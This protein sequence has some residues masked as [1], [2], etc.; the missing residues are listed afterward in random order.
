ML[1]LTLAALFSAQL[2]LARPAASSQW[3]AQE[4]AA[5]AGEDLEAGSQ[6][7]TKQQPPGEGSFLA[8]SSAINCTSTTSQLAPFTFRHPSTPTTTT[9]RQTAP[10]LSPTPT[11]AS[12]RFHDTL[13]IYY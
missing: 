5:S 9:L 11:T 10:P 12:R 3:T 4:W 1:L 2:A 7:A 13:T 6:Q 8:S